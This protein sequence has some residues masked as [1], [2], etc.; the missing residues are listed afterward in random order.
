MT[1]I[2]CISAS[3]L[4]DI[5]RVTHVI[6]MQ[7]LELTIMRKQMADAAEILRVR[8]F[9]KRGKIVR[10]KW[11][12]LFSTEEFKIAEDALK[13]QVTKR[14]KLRNLTNQL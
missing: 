10:L 1:A 9:R 2:E 7:S 6:E 5:H 3:P 14:L 8:K 13:K 12:F 11:K 4:K